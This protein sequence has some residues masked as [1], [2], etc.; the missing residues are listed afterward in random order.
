MR[1]GNKGQGSSLLPFVLSYKHTVELTCNF[2]SECESLTLKL[3]MCDILHACMNTSA[4]AYITLTCNTGAT[5]TRE[6]YK[7][8][9]GLS[10]RISFTKHNLLCVHAVCY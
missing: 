7:I 1:N 3:G 6:Y 9:V 4:R 8:I 5:I 10:E 2:T